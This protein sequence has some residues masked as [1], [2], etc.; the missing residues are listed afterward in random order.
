MISSGIGV[1][2]RQAA[3]GPNVH[4]AGFVDGDSTVFDGA[5]LSG[6]HLNVGV[7][8]N[9][10][11]DEVIRITEVRCRIDDD[12]AVHVRGGD[13]LDVVHVDGCRSPRLAG[14]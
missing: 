8:I 4:D 3:A 14:R 5:E 13:G 9:R 1:A 10:R 6:S 11:D 2:Q 7:G 12:I